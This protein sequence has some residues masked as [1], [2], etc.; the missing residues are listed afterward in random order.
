MADSLWNRT[1]T[2]FHA[3]LEL[4][5]S[6]R[7]PFLDR[8]CG[9]DEALRR[10]V[11]DLLRNVE[12]T[13]V[14]DRLPAGS[15]VGDGPDP[16]EGKR[17][18]RYLI[19]SR[20]GVGGMGLV[21][22]AEQQEPVRRRVAL[23]I[24]GPLAHP[25]AAARFALERQALALM[26]HPHI[27]RV[28]D[29]GTTDEGRPFIAMEY[30]EGLPVNEFCDR[31]ALD[32]RERLEL[33]VLV[34]QAV[35]HAHQKGIIHRDIKPTNVLVATVDGKAVPKVIDFGVAK[36]T[37]PIT[38][39]SLRTQ[40]G[41][42]VGTLEYMSP[43]QLDGGAAADIDTRSDIYSLGVLLYELLTGVLPYDWDSLRGEGLDALRRITRD[44]EPRRP[45]ERLRDA[46]SRLAAQVAAARRTTPNAL[47]RQLAGDLGWIVLKALDRDRARRYASASELA[48]D[49]KRYLADEPAL[50]GPPSAAYRLSKFVRRHRVGVS[51]AATI[52]VL[53]AGFAVVTMMQSL[54]IRRALDRARV[55]QAHAERVSTFLADVFRASDPYAG[56]GSDVTA[57]EVL[58]A[59]SR[60]I[61]TDL[62]DDD[63]VR[64]SVLTALGGV[65]AQLRLYDD[66][67]KL[68]REALSLRRN[69]HTGDHLETAESLEE[70]GHIHLRKS[71]YG[72][73]AKALEESVAMKRRLLP[74]S[75]PRR[76]RGLF[77]LGATR[78]ND[79]SLDAA[80]HHLLEA[81]PLTRSA[82]DPRI[83]RISADICDELG[84]LGIRRG[85]YGEA[86][87]WFRQAL[88][89]HQK[90]NPGVP[91]MADTLVR[92]GA[93]LNERG[94][95]A[96]G[97]VHLRAALDIFE[98]HLSPT[99]EKI[100]PA[101][102][103][104]ARCLQQQ[105]RFDEAAVL[106][107][108]ALDIWRGIH[109]DK[110]VG[111]ALALSNLGAVAT[112]QDRLTDAER[113][114]REA[115]AVQQKTLRPGH[116]DL[117]T[118]YNN[119]ARVHHDQ[120]RLQ[121][122]EELYKS[123]LELKRKTLK[124]DHILMPDTTL[125]YGKLL[126]EKRAFREAEAMMR[127][128]LRIREANLPPDDWRVAEAKSLLG[129]CLLAQGRDAEAEPLLVEGYEGVLKKRGPEWR[130]TRQAHERLLALKRR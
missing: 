48:D 61:A 8:E 13:G 62:E 40:H 39:D 57:R 118:S 49:V 37:H 103:N 114:Y 7:D 25:D 28:F 88:A 66:G 51:V 12:H 54:E 87:R 125:W 1:W 17:I 6:Q 113:Y 91:R 35:Q 30:V 123:A 121:S 67:E 16:L 38:G 5:P 59:S 52:A 15:F 90:E 4:D 94:D 23:K 46:D 101:A 85:D 53:L 32:V 109:G 63:Q 104:L 60:R 34:C 10:E 78:R 83:R 73:A 14:L 56:K 41:L 112:D 18:G 98:K 45:S 108:R 127:D 120:G 105:N 80:Q 82:A 76:A 111:V 33:F 119:L 102:N 122:A 11:G 31:N 42:V 68:V 106:Y 126:T 21:Y 130:R 69:L 43:E 128:G 81:L 27:A 20:A 71:N 107:T 58:D 19:R 22:D 93:V 84:S 72:A 2:L 50:A 75:D 115:L 29:A 129:S 92:L 74:P 110:H 3:A 89:V 47:V 36:A 44:T 79:G 70:L 100:A 99:H 95:P 116:P 86:E 124:P 24:M 55:E 97:E 96:G 77:L 9:A 117:A 64:A 65:Y 26:D